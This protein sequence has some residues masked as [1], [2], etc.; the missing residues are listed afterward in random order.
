MRLRDRL[1][2]DLFAQQALE[3]QRALAVPGEDDRPVAGF[4]DELVE[5]RGDV[6]IGEVER[7]LRV[8]ALRAGT[9]RTPPGG[10]AA[11]RSRPAP[12][13]ALAWLWTNSLVR[14]C[15]VAAGIE[16]RVPAVASRDRSSDGCRRS[17][18][19]RA[20]RGRRP[21]GQPMRGIVGQAGP[22]DPARRSANPGP[23]PA[24]AAS[25]WPFGVASL[26]STLPP[27]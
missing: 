24:L 21:S 16:R 18:P 27:H 8:L 3:V 2:G 20:G 11:P 10:S 9:R 7:L 22:R 14:N 5:R 23:P 19:C 1:A 4:L 25:K 26:S 12:L 17:P 6:A 13:N 15:G